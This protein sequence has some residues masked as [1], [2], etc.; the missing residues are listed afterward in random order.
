MKWLSILGFVTLLS[1]CAGSPVHT[2]SMSSDEL[3][4]VDE[5]T[6]CKAATPRPRYA[7]SARV[8]LE[9]KRRGVNCQGV[10]TYTPP[11]QQELPIII[12]QPRQNVPT[13]TTCVRTGQILNCT[14]Y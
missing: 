14:S 6:L 4:G 5:Y 9:V 8:M 2:S 12:E 3:E 13:R 1:S 10:Y 11:P 7:P